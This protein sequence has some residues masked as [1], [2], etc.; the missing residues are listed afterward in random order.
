MRLFFGWLSRLR[1]A[2][3]RH[4][5]G[6]L[7]GE[8]ANA[9]RLNRLILLVAAVVWTIWTGA[10]VFGLGAPW[11]VAVPAALL[12]T[13]IVVT[14]ARYLVGR[15]V[16]PR[17]RRDNVV[18][19][20][21]G[22]ALA[23]PV[24]GLLAVL[25]CLATVHA[26]IDA[27]R[28]AAVQ[29]QYGELVTPL[30]PQEESLRRQLAEA[31]TPHPETDPLLIGV[32]G[33]LEAKSAELTAAE[34]VKRDERAGHNGTGA[35][36]GGIWAEYQAT[37]NRLT[38]E[39]DDLA[40]QVETERANAQ[41]RADTAATER[42]KP[43]QQELNDVVAQI[44]ELDDRR[45]SD[46]QA[47][48]RDDFGVAEQRARVGALFSLLGGAPVAPAFWIT[49]LAYLVLQAAPVLLPLMGGPS[50]AD[51]A[52]AVRVRYMRAHLRPRGV[53]APGYLDRVP[54]RRV[55]GEGS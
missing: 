29:R 32:Q 52:A 26:D 27:A 35:G 48:H 30:R 23:L 36:P 44:K 41:L 1:G 2:A 11:F 40:R 17:H 39:R 46:I 45:K 14:V 43:V 3:P 7:E 49:L 54:R 5:A 53:D 15:V 34:N 16:A 21:A 18:A 50:E 10:L 42:A 28:I 13:A 6:A 22:T 37:V 9:G 24:G 31:H 33:K 51:D 55:P 8:L 4:A 12:P 47:V 38:R 19:A 20:L 25:I